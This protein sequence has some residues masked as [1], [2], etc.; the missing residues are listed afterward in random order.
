MADSRSPTSSPLIQCA[1]KKINQQERV[2]EPALGLFE[3]TFDWKVTE[4]HRDGYIVQYIDRQREPQDAD[5]PAQ[6]WE[7]WGVDHDYTRALKS[8]RS[9][10]TSTT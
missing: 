3:Y 10:D 1:I 9:Q 8:W 5:H 7:A 4:E 2:N 6:Y